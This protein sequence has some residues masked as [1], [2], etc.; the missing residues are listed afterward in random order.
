MDSY[1]GSI[2]LYSTGAVASGA[3]EVEG[4]RPEHVVGL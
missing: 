2:S 1:I 3:A 4:A